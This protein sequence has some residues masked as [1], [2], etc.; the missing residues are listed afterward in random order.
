MLEVCPVAVVLFENRFR[1]AM[2]TQVIPHDPHL[3]INFL[4]KVFQNQAKS[5]DL[6]L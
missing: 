3:A 1:F 6:A 5:S 2:G 4:V